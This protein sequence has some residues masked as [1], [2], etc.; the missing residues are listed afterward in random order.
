MNKLL[1]RH[2]ENDDRRNEEETLQRYYLKTQIQDNNNK[3]LIH[4]Q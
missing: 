1:H 3:R 4:I 2:D